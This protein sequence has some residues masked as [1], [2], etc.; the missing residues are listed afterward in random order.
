M[1][2]SVFFDSYCPFHELKDPGQIPLGLMD[3]GINSGVITNAKKDLDNYNAK[4]PLVKRI[5]KE[6]YDEEFWLENDSDTIIAYPL[7]GAYYSPLIEKMKQGKKKV[8]L[9]FDSD[10]KMAYPL[11]RH[12]FRVPLNERFTARNLVSDIWWHLASESAKRNRHANAAAETIKQIELSDGA[13]IESPEALTNLNY[14][15]AAWGRTDLIRK[16]FFVPNPVTPEFVEGEIGKKENVVVSYGRWDDF[17]QK[18]TAIMVET[19]AE[20]LK[21]RKDYRFVIFGKGTGYVKKFLE[22]APEKVKDRVEILG[23]VEREKIKLFLMNAKI[24]FVPSRWES[25]SIASAEA[26]CKGCSIVGTPLESLHFLSMQ[27]FS[28]TTAPLFDKG[29]IF[30]ALLQDS[31]KWDN[32]VYDPQKIAEFWRPILDRKSVAKSFQNLA[33]GKLA[34]NN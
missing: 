27:G 8:F 23:F 20:F 9:K 16:T 15:L 14:F 3:I 1:K 6:F 5:L 32:G 28:G 10:G 26:L 19:V 31:I 18:N 2:I 21:E 12:S 24:F 29:A 13:I 34:N 30:S 33:E 25:F 17:R 4:F 11:E 7:Q 22:V